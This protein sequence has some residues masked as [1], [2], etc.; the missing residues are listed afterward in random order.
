GKK[1]W[2]ANFSPIQAGKTWFY[3]RIESDG[4]QLL[5]VEGRTTHA[6]REQLSLYKT[7]YKLSTNFNAH[8]VDSWVLANSVTGGHTKPDL[9]EVIVL[10]P[11]SF[12]RRQLHRFNPSK[13]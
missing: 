2:N 3:T 7:S 4:F 5:K 8:C 12:C 11:L 9:T 6:L 1:R 13:G 10:K